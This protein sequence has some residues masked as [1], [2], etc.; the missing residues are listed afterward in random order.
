MDAYLFYPGG[1]A[2]TLHLVTEEA[3]GEGKYPVI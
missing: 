3:A 2:A 1:F